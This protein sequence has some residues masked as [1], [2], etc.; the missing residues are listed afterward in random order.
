MARILLPILLAAILLASG[1]LE[2]ITIAD[3]LACLELT[4]YSFTSIPE[5]HRQET[6]FSEI[7]NAFPFNEEVFSSRV[8]EHLFNAKNHLAKAWLFTN[9]AKANLKVINNQ[10]SVA[11]DLSLVPK[12]VNELN[13]NLLVIGNEIDEFNRAGV[14]AI[15][16]EIQDLELEDVNSIKEEFLFDDYSFESKCG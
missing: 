4:S 13:S 8:Q 11:T 10:C 2:N 6:C 3:R 14:Q 9:K 15:H 7:E 12:Q 5:C 1:C 16:F